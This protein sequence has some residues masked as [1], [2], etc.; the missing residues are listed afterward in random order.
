MKVWGGE[1]LLEEVE[2]RKHLSVEEAFDILLSYTTEEGELAES[3]YEK[4]ARKLTDEEQD[5]LI[6]MLTARGIKVLPMKVEVVAGLEQHPKIRS[7]QELS[8]GEIQAK[9]EEYKKR[10]LEATDA[11]GEIS[12]SKLDAILSEVLDPVLRS[13]LTDWITSTDLFKIKKAQE[14][15]YQ[16]RVKKKI[17]RITGMEVFER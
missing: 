9:L 4:V 6:G 3:I 10:I 11:K 2:S 15:E 1:I 8:E 14:T 12:Q 16:K 7:A 5:L 13:R 17:K